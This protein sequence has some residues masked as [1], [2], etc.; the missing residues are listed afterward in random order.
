MENS[1]GKDVNVANYRDDIFV[2]TTC[3][4]A[5]VMPETMGDLFYQ[6]SQ[7]DLSDLVRR[8]GGFEVQDS[9]ISSDGE[10]RV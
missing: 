6:L 5:K 9:I 8:T 4:N 10:V 1:R 3:T 2:R 7:S